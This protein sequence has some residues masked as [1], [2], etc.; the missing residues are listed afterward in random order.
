[1]N[2]IFGK[3]STVSH[4]S[5]SQGLFIVLSI[6]A[7]IL[8]SGSYSF[9]EEAGRYQVEFEGIKNKSLL[10]QIRNLSR[11]LEMSTESV[12]SISVLRIRASEDIDLFK[13]LLKS[14]GY[15]DAE[16]SGKILSD[17]KPWTVIFNFVLNTPFILSSVNI[18]FIPG[19][20][21]EIRVPDLSKTGMVLNR[22][23][24]SIK[25]LDGEEK[26]LYLI[27]KQ[28]FPYPVIEKREIIADHASRSVTVEYTIN[29]GKRAVFDDLVFKGLKDVD[30]TFLRKFIPWKKGEL[31]NPDLLAKCYTDLMNLGLF[32]TIKITEAKE[33]DENRLPIEIEVKERKHNSVSLGLNYYTDEGPGVNVSWENRNLFGHGE[34]LGFRFN[35]SN[36]LTTAESVF[37]KPA[38]LMKGQT[39]LLSLKKTHENPDAYTSDS[40]STSVS[41]D[42]ELKKKLGVSAGLEFKSSKVSQI[43]VVNSFS[44]LS[45][46]LMLDFNNSDDLLDPSKGGHLNVKLIPYYELSGESLFYN[47]GL[48][49]Y[50][51][52]FEIA[53]NPDIIFAGSVTVG[54]INGASRD[55]VP[56]DERF[57][58]GGGGS[59]RGYPYQSVGPLSGTTPLGGKSLLEMSGEAR[60]KMSRKIGLVLFMDGGSAFSERLFSPGEEVRWGTGIGLRYYTPIGPIRFDVGFPLNKRA[61][62][63]DS[64]QIY[65]SIGQAF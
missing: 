45:M 6:Y 30:Q 43:G 16:I 10:D 19:S 65:I 9:G 54:M 14:E 15:F 3:K 13:K 53:D 64:F 37:K 50:R 44:L 51:H 17:R 55:E 63:D 22:R 32:S 36:Y 4:Y 26:L 56:A 60:L 20:N 27:K 49:N 2:K 48:I 62:I 58:A 59:V 34:K 11:T 47:K 39:L 42:R 46:P 23:Y 41:L 57:Y 21:S 18:R 29:P 8:L 5:S 40:I 61:G 31:Y 24:Q 33:L 38:F 35:L 52:Y 25:I 7:L 28:G 1:M 12:G